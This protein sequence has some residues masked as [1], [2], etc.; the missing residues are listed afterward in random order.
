MCLEQGLVGVVYFSGESGLNGDES[1]FFSRCTLATAQ[2][3]RST[4]VSLVDPGLVGISLQEKSSAPLYTVKLPRSD[5]NLNCIYPYFF[6]TFNLGLKQL[7]TYS[8]CVFQSS[9]GSLVLL[10]LLFHAYHKSIF[11]PGS[12]S[13]HL[14]H[15]QFSNSCSSSFQIFLSSFLKM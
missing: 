3:L 9:L 10:S 7:S 15:R 14:S 11:S 2:H 12:I 1:T 5:L 6:P 8:K 4:L 13:I